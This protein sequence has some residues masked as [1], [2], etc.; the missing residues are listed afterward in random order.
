MNNADILKIAISLYS[1]HEI[2]VA[3]HTPYRFMDCET[4]FV[5]RRGGDASKTN[6]TNMLRTL[7]TAVH[8][9]VKF[10]VTNNR[11]LLPVSLDHVDV[12]AL[13]KSVMDI[14]TE[15]IKCQENLQ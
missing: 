10:C 4:D 15:L 13:L 7:A 2:K 6:I 14:R 11:Q 3:K 8:L 9:Q 5:D 12:A 1:E